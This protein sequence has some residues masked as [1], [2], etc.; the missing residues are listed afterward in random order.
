MTLLSES[1][2]ADESKDLLLVLHRGIGVPGDSGYWVP[3]TGHLLGGGGGGASLG[4]FMGGRA[5][6]ADPI[7]APSANLARLIS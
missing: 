6:T 7:S 2:M 4:W 5:R 1:A 3:G